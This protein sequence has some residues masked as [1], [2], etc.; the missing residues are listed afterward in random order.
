MD[1]TTQ[2]KNIETAQR[3]KNPMLDLPKFNKFSNVD[4]QCSIVCKL[5]SELD[6]S[7]L[8]WA[9]KLAEKNVGGHYKA[10]KL[11]W[12]PKIKQKDLNKVWAR[13]LIATDDSTKKNIA[14]AMFRFDLDYGSS[15][16]YCYEMQVEDG[17]QCK[18]LGSFLMEALEAIGQLW[19]MEKIVLTL[20][21]NN[22]GA[23]RFYK[24]LG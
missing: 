13:Y 6:A 23:Q 17:Y 24:R 9:F 2:Q 4:L 18:G 15:V 10:C 14:Y 21:K 19:K 5:K 12:Q 3:S 16:L 11:G 22:P 8:K 20:L 7:V 1:I